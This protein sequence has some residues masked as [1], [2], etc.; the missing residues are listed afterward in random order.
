MIRIY[1]YPGSK[2]DKGKICYVS[3]ADLNAITLGVIPD[4]T[5]I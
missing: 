5:Q 3:E 4:P 2:T 1:Q